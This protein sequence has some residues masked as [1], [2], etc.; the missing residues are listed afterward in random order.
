MGSSLAGEKTWMDVGRRRVG[1]RWD[2]QHRRP[3]ERVIAGDD[4]CAT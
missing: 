3:P 2:R 1:S 4:P